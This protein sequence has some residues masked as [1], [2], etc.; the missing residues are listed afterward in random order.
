VKEVTMS[1]RKALEARGVG[2]RRVVF[3]T[4]GAAALVVGACPE[5]AR[6]VEDVVQ[7]PGNGHW[8]KYVD[9]SPA[10]DWNAC[11][12]AAESMGG[13][14]AGVPSSAEN[15][16]ILQTLV[17]STGKPACWLGGD[18]AAAEGLWLWRD[19]SAFGFANWSPGEPSD[20]DGTENWLAMQTDGTW[21]DESAT[22]TLSG[23]VVEWDSDP[24]A[25]AIPQAPANLAA[26]YV[27]GMGVTLTW[28]DSGTEEAGF[29]VERMLSGGSF[30]IRTNTE[31]DVATWTDFALA[32]TQTYTYRVAAFNSAGTSAYSNEVSIT[33]AAAEPEPAPPEAPSGLAALATP[34]PS[35]ELS[36]ADNSDDEMRFDLERAEGGAGFSRR[37][38]P[39]SD[40]IGFTDGSVHPGWPYA[41]RVRAL[42]ATGASA[43]SNTV[44]VTVPA[45]LGLTAP[46]GVLTH[47]RKP[48]RDTLKL[49]SAFTIGLPGGSLDPVGAGLHMQV[50]PAAA[51][52]AIEIGANDPGWKV[53]SRKG[54]PVKA[55]WKTAKRVS[56]KVALTVDLA[57][58]TLVVTASGADFSADTSANV[59]LLVACGEN[60]GAE[61]ATWA[62]RKPGVLQR[63]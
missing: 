43:Y 29:V 44:T 34:A 26:S 58:G 42:G 5:A 30:A 19:G 36:W 49:A 59:R 27:A 60:C 16:W 47:A 52:L 21:T 20:V 63:K 50:G 39:A 24:N 25:V 57:R 45:T 11:R 15:D 35:V 10:M 14:L 1:T 18:D 38:N 55:T 46:T 6:A 41:Y 54:V 2:A 51:P 9:A 61:S 7:N 31:A 62:V 37:A 3:L 13:R 56:P 22:Q 28:N 40:A 23:Y 53:K 4:F 48:S 32:P 33:T 12:I 17:A 8:Y